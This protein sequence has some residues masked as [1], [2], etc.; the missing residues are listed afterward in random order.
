MMMSTGDIYTPG[1]M[2]SAGQTYSQGVTT[3]TGDV[4]GQGMTTSTG[5]VYGQGMTTSTGDVY[6]QG[7]QVT[8]PG[9]TANS[10]PPSH[11][12]VGTAPNCT[13]NVTNTPTVSGSPITQSA[14]LLPI[15]VISTASADPIPEPASLAL[16]APALLWLGLVRRRRSRM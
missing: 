10:P 11:G 7:T 16:L 6:G 13:N 15:G 8:T 4:Y 1:M 14:N 5:D 2:I 3:S 9:G 12:C